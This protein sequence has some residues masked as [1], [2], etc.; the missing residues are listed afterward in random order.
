[1]IMSMSCVTQLDSLKLCQTKLSAAALLRCF[2]LR[3]ICLWRGLDER[4][5]VGLSSGGEKY[6]LA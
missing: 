2:Y 3:L 1:M 5:L 4:L 6:D